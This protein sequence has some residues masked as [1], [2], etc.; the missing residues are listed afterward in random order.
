MA[1]SKSRSAKRGTRR[2]SDGLS[3]ATGP[4]DAKT[5]PVQPSLP[6]PSSAV[7]SGRV[8]PLAEHPVVTTAMGWRI[9]AFIVLV[10]FGLTITFLMD[11]KFVY[12]ALWAVVT[13]GWGFFTVKLYRRHNEFVNSF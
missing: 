1:R 13:A 11:A 12:G 7:A 6:V 5:K 8:E 10:F 3:R 2:P 9:M 4:R